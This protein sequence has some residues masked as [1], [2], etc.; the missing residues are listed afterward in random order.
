MPRSVCSA[1]VGCLQSGLPSGSLPGS[2]AVAVSG[3][4]APLIAWAAPLESARRTVVALHLIS[5]LKIRRYDLVVGK[6]NQR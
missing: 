1:L 5:R 4:V 3:L 6:Q 2:V